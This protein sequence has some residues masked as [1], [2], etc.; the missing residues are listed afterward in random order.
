[1]RKAKESFSNQKSSILK[2][3]A[4]LVTEQLPQFK[5][6]SI[7]IWVRAGS[8]HE[9]PKEAGLSHFL[10]HMIF[11][12][13]TTRSA[14]DIALSL[15][16]V[17]GE[18]NAFTSREYTCFHVLLLSKDLQLAAEILSDVLLNST[19]QSDEIE[20]EKK[21]VLQEIA[22]VEENPEEWLHDY[23][24]EESFG[25]HSLGLP[26][27]GSRKSV[28]SFDRDS[29]VEFFKNHY[30]PQN[31]VISVAGNIEHSEVEKYFNRY[32]NSFGRSKTK[33]KKAN[34]SKPKFTPGTNYVERDV[35]QAHMLFSFPSVSIQDKDR[36]AALLLNTYLG[37]GM[38]SSLFQEIREKRGLAY[39]VYS[40]LSPFT[41]A[42][43]F[44]IY[45]G[46][47]ADAISLCT[48]VLFNETKKLKEKKLD[49]ETL[50]ILKQNLQGTILLN[51]DSVENRMMSIARNQ[52]FFNKQFSLKEMMRNIEKVS[53]D[54]VFKVAKKTF[55]SKTMQICVA[56]PKGHKR[57]FMKQLTKKF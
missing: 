13:T 41:D 44:T 20:R 35:E 17:G 19:F 37:G 29:T 8:R 9:K 50:E 30:D 3:G 2:N 21:V 4:V 47:S 45:V 32:L 26:I 48:E 5:S 14:L 11:K 33:T 42:G 16:R 25:G 31:L 43:L 18:F 56:A 53:V 6:L 57:S 27:L 23:L 34:L 51:S 12:G 46:T 40:S 24:F 36:F 1:M 10:E 38:S 7:G 52:M 28:E 54:D 15:D 49:K 39:S 55:Q 22:M